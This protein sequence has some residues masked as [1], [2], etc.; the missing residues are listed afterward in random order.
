MQPRRFAQLDVFADQALQGNAL[1]VVLDGEGISDAAMLD[2]ARWTNLSETTFVLP[3]T[4]EG[5]AGGADYRLRIFTPAGELAFAGHPTLGSCQ[6]W[7]NAGGRPRQAQQVVQECAKGLVSIQR[8]PSASNIDREGLAFAAPPLQRSEVPASVQTEVMA[9]LA[10][11]ADDL[12]AAQWLDNGSRWMGLLVRDTDVLPR[13]QPNAAALR[14]LGV[15][16]GLCAIHTPSSGPMAADPVLEVRGITLTAHGIA[17]D[18]AT[19]SLNASLAQWLGAAGHIA[20]PYCVQQGA[21]IG[22]AGRMR[23]TIDA[24]GQVWAQGQVHSVLT[25]QVIL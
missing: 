23:L 18:P 11:Q 12:V 7:L 17:E 10:L 21:A 20:L 13:A 15:K 3:P 9:A 5:A 4:A 24:H 16:A 19:G 22:R 14:A 8:S 2:F 1:A 6:A 25:G